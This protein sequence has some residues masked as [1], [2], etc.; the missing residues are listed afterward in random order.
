MET[1]FPFAAFQVKQ[2][3]A[4]AV[5]ISPPFRMFRVF[6]MRPGV[7]MHQMCIRDRLYIRDVVTSITRPVKELKGFQ[8]IFLKAGEMCIRDSN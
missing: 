5:E 4:L 6:E 8:K 7:V 3:I 2:H 1:P